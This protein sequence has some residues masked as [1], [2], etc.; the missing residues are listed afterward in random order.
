MT[1]VRILLVV[2]CLSLGPLTAWG[3]ATLGVRADLSAVEPS[4]AV[5]T[6][7]LDEYKRGWLADDLSFGQSKNLGNYPAW[8]PYRQ[9]RSDAQGLIRGSGGIGHFRAVGFPLRCFTLYSFWPMNSFPRDSEWGV[10]FTRIPFTERYFDLPVRPIWPAL[11]VDVA[12]FALVWGVPVYLVD[13]GAGRLRRRRRVKRG[14][15]GGCGF[16]RTGLPA[17]AACPEY[18]PH[19]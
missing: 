14:R 10:R 6:C 7:D 2:A 8:M 16:P 1:A 3:L 13:R 4:P 12:F 15:C 19:A 17:D 5:T 11:A 18:G 9:W